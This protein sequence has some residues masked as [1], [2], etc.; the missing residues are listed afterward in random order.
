MDAGRLRHKIDLL[1]PVVEDLDKGS[2]QTFREH[3]AGVLASVTPKLVSEADAGSRRRGQYSGPVR[4]YRR[5]AFSR[6]RGTWVGVSRGAATS[7]ASRG[8]IDVDAAKR[9]LEMGCVRV[10]VKTKLHPPFHY[11]GGKTAG[12]G[13]SLGTVRARRYIRG[14]VRRAALRCCSAIRTLCRRERLFATRTGIYAMSG[15]RCPMIPKP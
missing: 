15:V 10:R 7:S 13:R 9:W 12:G 1:E 3:A 6:R 8:M 11:Y 2:T 14:A 4:Y 5:R